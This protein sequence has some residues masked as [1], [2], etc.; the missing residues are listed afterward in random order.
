MF[1]NILSKISPNKYESGILL[2][3]YVRSQYG[4]FLKTNIFLP[5]ENF[6]QLIIKEAASFIFFNAA[7]LD[8]GCA[9]G[10]LVFEF[11]KMGAKKSVGIDTSKQFI[12]FCNLVKSRGFE[13]LNFKALSSEAVFLCADVLES[14]F[15]ENSF[16]LISCINLLDRVISPKTLIDLLYLYL[17]PQGALLLVDPYDW[18]LSPAPKNLHVPDMKDLLNN[19]KWEVKKEI[20]DIKYTI[21]LNDFANRDY[22]CHMVIVKK[23]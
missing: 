8:A 2:N 17:K 12:D 22:S 10:R 16:D 14:K 3:N 21:P 6:Y 15:E 7:V 23:R 1:K 11:E 18:E 20:R 9:T 4:P 13:L 5:S 19:E